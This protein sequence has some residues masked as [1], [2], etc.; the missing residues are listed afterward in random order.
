MRLLLDTN[1]LGD[2]RRGSSASLDAWLA[3]QSLADL[4]VSTVTIFEIEL[5]VSRVERRD[6][7]QGALLRRWL[8]DVVRPTFAGRIL[9]IDE[10]VAVAAARL[11]VP[12]PMP[13]PDSLIA[14][15]ALVHGLTLVTR[16]TKDFERTDVPLLNP[17]EE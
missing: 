1:V 10:A 9:A 16:N 17:W 5:G 14:A 2:A 7:Q 8:D 11:H 12:D 3:G 6:D 13:I 4:A 15:T